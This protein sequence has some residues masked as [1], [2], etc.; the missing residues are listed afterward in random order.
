MKRIV[1]HLRI[2]NCKEEIEYYQNVFGGES[3]IPSCLTALKCLKAMKEST[4]MPNCTSMRIA[5]YTWLMYLGKRRS[6][7]V[8]FCSVLTLTAKKK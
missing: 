4:F 8:I 1:P 2:E 6:K 7:A 3:K 5:F